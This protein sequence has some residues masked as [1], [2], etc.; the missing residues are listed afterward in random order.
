MILA[1]LKYSLLLSAGL[2]LTCSHN[3]NEKNSPMTTGTLEDWLQLRDLTRTE[4][5]TLFPFTGDQVREGLRYEQLAPVTHLYN[6]AAHPAHFYFQGEKMVMLY[7]SDPQI[8]KAISVAA[9]REKY[10]EGTVLRSRAGKT[11]TH[12]VYP[13]SG[14]AFSADNKQQIL[15]LEI[16]PP[17]ALDAYKTQIYMEPGPFI[18]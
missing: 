7:L 4:L 13:E 10:G 8:L 12:I 5:Q 11:A 9:L 16:F 2:A 6:P 1:I 17:S 15:F 14:L 3:G 18:K